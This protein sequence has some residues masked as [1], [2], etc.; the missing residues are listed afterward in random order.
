MIIT[1]RDSMKR[2]KYIQLLLVMFFMMFWIVSL[3]KLEFLTW[4]HGAKFPYPENISS[5]CGEMDFAKVLELTDANA[6][7]YY[8]SGSHN[9]GNTATF[10]C[11]GDNWEYERWERTIWST[12]GSADD[13]V[14]PYWYHSASGWAL[15]AV[16]GFPILIV[17][18]LIPLLVGR[19]RKVDET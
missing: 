6:R 3:I 2:L 10:I 7:I 15:F 8:V 14:W 11:R 16:I 4:Q 1:R 17:S 18:I 5:M 13:F 12:T 9:V 19:R